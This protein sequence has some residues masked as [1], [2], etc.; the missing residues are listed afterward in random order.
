[1][2]INLKIII[3][4]YLLLVLSCEKFP[5]GN[6]SSEAENNPPNTT[7]ANIPREGA[8]LYA[9]VNFNWDGEDDDGY[10][11]YYQYRYTTEYLIQSDEDTGAYY[12]TSTDT[13]GQLVTTWWKIDS[14]MVQDWQSIKE[15]NAVIAFNSL[16]ILNHQLFE[17]RAVDNSGNVDESPA[18]L[19]FYTNQTQ[20]PETEITSPLNN[21][22]FLA[23]PEV[24]DWY[25][26]I[27]ITFT[28]NDPDGNI[29]E[30][31]WRVDGGEWNWTTDTSVIIPPT[32]WSEPLEEEHIITVISRDDTYL[33]DPVGDSIEIEIYV[34]TFEKDILI[35]DGTVE[36]ASLPDFD[37]LITDEMTDSAYYEIFGG[38]RG[39]LIVDD[40]DFARRRFPNLSLIHI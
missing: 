40:R 12:F 34:P 33:I 11:D 10:I 5:P 4:L 6:T 19:N 17:V 8:T 37:G 24:D 36:D 32:A 18:S 28:A 30:Y 20:F 14:T 13:S 31:A 22:D 15:T 3:N 9:L 38:N 35:L 2:R 39:D 27:P 21:A 16:A 1:M 25:K 29:T 23:K 7:L 26:G